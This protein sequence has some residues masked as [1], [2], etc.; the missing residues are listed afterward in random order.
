MIVCEELRNQNGLEKE[1]EVGVENQEYEISYFKWKTEREGI[2]V[3]IVYY[4]LGRIGGE[5]LGYFKIKKK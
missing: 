4:F 5:E 1:V 3:K 2:R